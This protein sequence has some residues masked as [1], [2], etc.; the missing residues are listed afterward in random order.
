[1]GKGVLVQATLWGNL[2]LGPTAADVADPATAKRTPAEIMRAILSK[3]V[4]LVPNFD[5]SEVVSGVKHSTHAEVLCAI[6]L[7]RFPLL[8][9]PDPHVFGQP[10][11]VQPRRLDH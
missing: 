2:I 4:E 6:I 3:C 7:C 1:M 10:R 8:L 11:K 5:A 9:P